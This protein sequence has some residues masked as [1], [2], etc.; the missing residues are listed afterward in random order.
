[1][2]QSDQVPPD[3]PEEETKIASEAGPLSALPM[4]S[5]RSSQNPKKK[6]GIRYFGDYVLLGEIAHGGMGVV[7]QALQTSL[8]REVAIKM[9]YAGQLASEIGFRRFQ[10]EAEAMAKLDH[11]NIVSIYEVGEHEGQ[12]YLSMKLIDG[13]SLA[14]RME[15]FALPGAKAKG[16]SGSERV[17]EDGS[18][19]GKEADNRASFDQAT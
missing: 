2:D 8:D 7:Y 1:M 9:I 13:A 14:Q 12:Q 4:F 11:P 3:Q 17:S 6:S 16:S 5:R 19:Q 10:T 18:R 15:E